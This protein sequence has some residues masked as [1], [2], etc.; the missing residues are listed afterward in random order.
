MVVADVNAIS[1]RAG[2]LTHGSRCDIRVIFVEI[3]I[4]KN[5][6]QSRRNKISL[7]QDVKMLVIGSQNSAVK[8]VRSVAEAK[9]DINRAITAR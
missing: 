3:A 1:L 8:Y 9:R 7:A 6:H 4:N 5:V 2:I